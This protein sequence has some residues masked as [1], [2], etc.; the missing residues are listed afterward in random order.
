MIIPPQPN[1]LLESVSKR[2]ISGASSGHATRQRDAEFTIEFVAY[3][4]CRTLT[5]SRAP[6]SLH[7]AQGDTEPAVF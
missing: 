3:I 4:W 1:P 2:S 7:L 6:S 5:T